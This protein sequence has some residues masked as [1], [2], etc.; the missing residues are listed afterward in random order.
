MKT[1]ECEDD[2][3]DR[4]QSSNPV[5]GLDGLSVLLHRDRATLIADRCRAPDRVPPAYRVAGTRQPLWLV[6]DVLQ[7][8]RQHPEDEALPRRPG[9]PKKTEQVHRQRHRMA[10]RRNDR[11]VAGGTQQ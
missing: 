6:E 2:L 9:R 7:W 4:P 1:P 10:A 5:V 11:S 8:L 3:A